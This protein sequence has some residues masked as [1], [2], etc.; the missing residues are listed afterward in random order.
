MPHVLEP[1]P[2]AYDALEPHYDAATLKLHHDKHHRAYVEKL[3]EALKGD[4]H[5]EGKSLEALL[6]NPDDI[7]PSL[8]RKVLNNAGGAWNHDF[9]WKI[10]GPG[11]GGAPTGKVGEAINA[12]FGDFTAFQAKWKESTVNVFG[13]GWTWLV[14]ADKKVEIREFANQDTPIGKGLKGLLT[15]DLWEHAYYLKFQ[16]RRPDWVDAWWN[17]VD[18]EAVD[19][20]WSA[21]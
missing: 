6:K 13:S 15:I 3:N 5:L 8:R 4:A 17:V 9:F 12:T 14:R 16:N 1:L 19:A 18:W 7:P 2:Y 21:R 20:L 10:M 11:K